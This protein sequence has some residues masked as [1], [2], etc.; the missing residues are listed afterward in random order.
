MKRRITVLIL[1]LLLI[2]LSVPVAAKAETEKKVVRVGWYDSSF[3]A[4][5]KN[6]RR[7]GYAYEYQL[8]IAAYTGWEYQYV[9]GS[10]TQLM[11]MLKDGQIDLLSDVSYTK[12]REESMLFPDLP[13]GEEEYCIFIMP[14][15]RDITSLDLSTLNGK[16]IGANKG[17]IQAEFF[18][19]WAE[20]HNVKAEL[21]DLTGTE[22]ESFDMLKNGELDAYITLNAYGVAEKLTPVVKIGSSEFYFAVAKEQTGLL[23]EL[24]MAMGRIR[25][26]DPYYNLKLFEKY[27]NRIGSNAFLSA[28]ELSWLEAHG[29]IRVGYQDNYLAFCASDGSGKLT[30][31]LKDYLEL[32]QDVL[33][34][35][36]IDF[37]AKAYPTAADAMDALEKGEIDCV[38]PANLSSYDGE[39]RHLVMTPAIMRT[40]IF[41]VVRK[42]EESVF[43]RKEHVVVAENEGNPNYDAFLIE[44]FPAWTKVYYQSTADG[45]KAVS[46][47]VADCVLV[48]SYRFN[49]ISRLCSKYHLAAFTTGIGLDY[50]FAVRQGETDL[51]S[52]L[53]KAV[54]MVPT[55]TVNTMLSY[56]STEDAKLTV[57]D[58][59]EDNLTWIVAVL[60]AIL[61]LSLGLFLWRRNV[62]KKERKKAAR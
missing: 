55:S 9:S 25:D 11:D 21:I 36:H 33:K 46:E 8:K 29:A 1:C 43:A 28:D 20:K 40:D 3:N 54:G 22:D 23:E 44:N 34:N 39:T 26:E 2:S 14:E 37:E 53:A 56:Y 6:G 62:K 19:Q 49:N 24:N 10:W 47:G 32:A 35:A 42:T 31:A 30:G 18:L 50:C 5:D 60:E 57:G 38:F 27:V 41:A 51:Y 4:K 48:S 58:V 45:L 17:S 61:L 15:N 7:S 52:I 12:E 16:K 13:M 59:L